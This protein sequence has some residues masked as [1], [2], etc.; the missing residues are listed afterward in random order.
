MEALRT[1]SISRVSP[2]LLAR[3]T[4]QLSLVLAIAIGTWLVAPQGPLVVAGAITFVI[5]AI[6]AR[7]HFE[8]TTAAVLFFAYTATGLQFAVSATFATAPFWLAGLAGLAAGGTSWTEWRSP[9]HW[10]WPLLFWLLAVALSWPVIV[11]RETDF[12]FSGPRDFLGF[13]LATTVT[14]L[15][16]G[17]WF[18]SVLT[19][20]ADRIRRRIAWPLLASAVISGCAALYQGLVDINW[21]SASPWSDHDR[22]VGLMADANPMAVAACIWAPLAVVL[23][24]ARGRIGLTGK[25]IGVMLCIVLWFAAW[26]TGSRSVVLLAGAGAVGLVGSE[27]AKRI[28]SARALIIM[29]VVAIAAAA[30]ILSIGAMAPQTTPVGR[31]YRTL[32]LASPQFFVYETLWRR[33]GYGLAAV[34]AIREHPVTGVGVGAFNWLASHYHQ[35]EGERAL[36]AD[37]AQN[38]WRNALAERGIVGLAALIG[39]TFTALRLLLARPAKSAQTEVWVLKA[40]VAALAAV[41]IFGLPTQ[42]PAIALTAAALLAW[43]HAAVVTEKR[44]APLPRSVVIAAWMLAVGGVAVD[45]Y[46]ATTALRP[47]LRAL[48]VGA[49]YGYG[50][51]EEIAGADGVRYRV[52]ERDAAVVMAVSSP[53]FRLRCWVRGNA[54]QRVRV[55]LDR[56][57]VI[58]EQ[59]NAGT[60]VERVLELPQ[61]VANVLLEIS[62][63]PPGLLVVGEAITP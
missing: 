20:D 54:P 32:P 16:A 31:L 62:S 47:S 28:G 58:D 38:F 57:V 49:P 48:R 35:L 6:A 9:R 22:A 59:A 3:F 19:W 17:L 36:P 53:R 26:L 10:Q 5:V 55:W 11:A 21:L 33:D 4:V 43:L 2:A 30:V 8:Y 18:D 37:N 24:S 7:V 61:G 34:R 40:V 14:H 13:I 12:S 41:L 46:A 45:G 60:M 27:V 42:S 29:C 1:G 44:P 51:G 25:T 50:F 56:R 63:T 23:L 52:V 39:F 15:A